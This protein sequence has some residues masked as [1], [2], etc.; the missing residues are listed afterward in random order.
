MKRI[1]NAVFIGILGTLFCNSAKADFDS[2][3][4]TT[5]YYGGTK[6]YTI[7][8]STGEANLVSTVCDPNGACGSVSEVEY[9]ESTSKLE[10]KLKNKWYSYD[11][12]TGAETEIEAPWALDYQNTG[13][14]P[15]VFK[16]IENDI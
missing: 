9:N 7:N 15:K 13:S 1:L 14:L 4:Y 10:Y 6:F 11:L 2:W 8:S 16:S 5:E 12:N 3:G